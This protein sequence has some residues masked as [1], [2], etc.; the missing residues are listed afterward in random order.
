MHW[1]QLTDMDELDEI[2]KNS[3]NKPILIFKHST[4]CAI[5]RMALKQFEKEFHPENEITPYFL[6]LLQHRDISNEIADRF[7]VQHQ[8]PQLLLIK[9]GKCIHNTSHE[10]IDA[11]LLSS[12]LQQK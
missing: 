3:S 2:F 6:D 9:D 11:S 7:Q 10:A 1:D 12:A 8:S 5:S 4:R